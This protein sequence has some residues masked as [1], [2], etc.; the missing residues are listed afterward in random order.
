MTEAAQLIAKIV[1]SAVNKIINK[2]TIDSMAIKNPAEWN[3]IEKNPNNIQQ[4]SRGYG[5]SRY[6]AGS[7]SRAAIGYFTFTL[8]ASGI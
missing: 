6:T 4:G 7:C 1:I 5:K 3:R 2:M 8:G